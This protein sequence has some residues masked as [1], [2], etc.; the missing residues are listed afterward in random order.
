[1]KI[2]KLRLIFH[3]LTKLVFQELGSLQVNSAVLLKYLDY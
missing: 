2:N 1:M 3:L